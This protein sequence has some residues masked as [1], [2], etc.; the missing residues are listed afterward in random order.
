METFLSCSVCKGA[1][2]ED[3]DKPF[4][5]TC[6]NRTRDSGFKLKENRG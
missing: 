4:S 2:K 6:S 5:D 1:S 3:G